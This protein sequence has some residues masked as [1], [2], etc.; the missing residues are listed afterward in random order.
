MCDGVVGDLTLVE[1]G[2]KP[3]AKSDEESYV[4]G[5]QTLLHRNR[6]G[7]PRA[8]GVCRSR[9]DMKYIRVT[10]M[11]V[12][13]SVRFSALHVISLTKDNT[14]TRIQL[15]ATSVRKSVIALASA[16]IH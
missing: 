4:H 9:T 10:P 14:F 8:N 16:R 6:G 13:L 1:V 3:R 7:E 15:I 12:V 2:E 11:G 5:M